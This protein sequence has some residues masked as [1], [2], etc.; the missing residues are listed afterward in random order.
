MKRPYVFTPQPDQA[1]RHESCM[2][3]KRESHERARCRSDVVH[4]NGMGLGGRFGVDAQRAEII[5]R[6]RIAP[7]MMAMVMAVWGLTR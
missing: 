3:R 2:P 7:R 6:L 5:A 4:A 1:P